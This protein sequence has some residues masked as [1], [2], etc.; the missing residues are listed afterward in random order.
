MNRS[1][2]RN[3]QGI[4]QNVSG[5]LALQNN[6]KKNAVYT[7]IEARLCRYRGTAESGPGAPFFP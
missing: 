5:M 4:S 6:A 7:S 1:R 2:A 3:V